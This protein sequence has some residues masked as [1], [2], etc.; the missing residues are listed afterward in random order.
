MTTNV[1]DAN[2]PVLEVRSALPILH[3]MD[4]DKEA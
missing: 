1:P 3:G 4:T 2:G